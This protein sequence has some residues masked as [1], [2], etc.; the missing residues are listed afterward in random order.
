MS[1]IQYPVIFKF[2]QWQTKMKKVCNE[3]PIKYLERKN[4]INR[5]EQKKRS[6]ASYLLFGF[7]G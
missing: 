6:W 4:L 3:I 1:K 7:L 5:K 2:Y